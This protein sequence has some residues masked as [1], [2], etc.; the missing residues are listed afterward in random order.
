MTDFRIQSI[1]DGKY[2]LVITDNDFTVVGGDANTWPQEVAQRIVYEVCTWYGES[3]FDRDAGFPWAQGVFGKAPLEGI[4]SLAYE[5]IL[6]VDGVQGF[7]E[8]PQLT[9]DTVSRRLF[10]TADVLG[11]GFTVPIETTIV[12]P[13]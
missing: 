5:K 10:I 2:D 7:N 3:A 13:T 9:L 8:Q 6:G 4:A 1:G 12:G 11:D